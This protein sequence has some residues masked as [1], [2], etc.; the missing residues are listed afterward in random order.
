MEL[1]DFLNSINH[2]K[3]P[4]LDKDEKAQKIYPAFIVNKCLSYFPDTIFHSNEMNCH[5]WLDSKTQFDFY[6]MA[7]RK[8][9]RFSHWIKKETEE[10]ILVIKEVFGYTDSKA[11]EVLNILSVE[12]IQKLKSYLQK[13]GVVN[14]Q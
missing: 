12:D 7:V 10:N 2:D 3:K 4:L 5:P 6:R 9:K 11:K 14:K 13:G 8:K 1:K